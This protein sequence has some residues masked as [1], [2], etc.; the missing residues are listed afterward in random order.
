MSGPVWRFESSETGV[1]DLCLKVA[2]GL[3]VEGEVA[4]NELCAARRICPSCLRASGPLVIS[5]EAGRRRSGPAYA[6]H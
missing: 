1:C 2:T 6:G 4:D 5:G 3:Y